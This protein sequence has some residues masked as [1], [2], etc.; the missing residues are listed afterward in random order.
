MKHIK[1]YKLFEADGPL[2]PGEWSWTKDLT[3]PHDIQMDIYDMA[4]ELKDEGYNVLFQWWPPY[5]KSSKFYKGNKYPFISI[6]KSNPN[7]EDGLE[8]I[9]HAWIKDFCERISSYLDE[10]D[11]NTVVKFRKVNTNDYY[12]I[13]KSYPNQEPF[14]NHHMATS[15]HFKI[16]MISRKVYGDVHES[17]SCF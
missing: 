7:K 5:E 4:F 1:T 8:K 13:N 6:T 3:I 12:D 10:K 9:S 17:K 14:S 16:E 2:Q 11:Y 15:I